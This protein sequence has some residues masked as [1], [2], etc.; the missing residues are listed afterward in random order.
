MEEN[1]D[2]FRDAALVIVAAI[3][4]SGYASSI[5]LMLLT[6]LMLRKL[7]ILPFPQKILHESGQRNVSLFWG[8]TFASLFA[9]LVVINYDWLVA[10]KLFGIATSAEEYLF[11]LVALPL[12]LP[13]FLLTIG[14]F[15][16]TARTAGVRSCT[17]PTMT[18]QTQSQ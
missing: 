12:P 13:I 2:Q 1:T 8:F 9:M 10:K 15:Y 5:G 16:I 3:I 6:P 14:N 18:M 4:F 17:C 11:K 7:G